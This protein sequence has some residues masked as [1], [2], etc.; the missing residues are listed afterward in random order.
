M[1]AA[2]LV[3]LGAKAHVLVRELVAL[4]GS[5]EAALTDDLTGLG[6]RRSLLS[7]LE[8]A[9]RG[10]EPVALLLLDLDRFKHVNDGLGHH[11]GDE[12]LRQVA[13]RLRAAMVPGSVLARLGG[14]EFAVLLT[15]P[16][17]RVAEEVALGVHAALQRP[18]VVDGHEVHAPGSV[19][20]ALAPAGSAP[21]RGRALDLLRRADTAM[22]A[23]KAA[24]SGVV[25][26][27]QHHDQRAREVIETAEELRAALAGDQ[28]L[29]HY[30]PQLAVA[31]G[32]LL[33]VEALL[34][35]EHPRRGLLGP[36]T[37]LGAAHELGVLA[38]VT[39]LVLRTA[40]AQAAAWRDAGT[41]VRVS[42][43]LTAADVQLALVGDVAELLA[44][45][46][47]P[48]RLLVLEITETSVLE[49]LL[50]AAAVLEDL[51]ALGVE[52]SVDDFGT[53]HSSLTLLLQLPVTEVKV[54]R[55]FVGAVCHDP[56]R[57]TVVRTTVE[58]AHGLGMRVVA[59]GVEDAA[60]LAQLRELG[61][62]ASQ[63]YLHS[64]ALAPEQL[65]CWMRA[66]T[67]V[68]AG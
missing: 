60:V 11:A 17:A 48:P 10:H 37:F 25:V 38:D 35:W 23:A 6:N 66:R 49:D 19:G 52:I 9:L 45:H 31:D 64:R 14:D 5:H 68:A 54:D 59:E 41:P 30:Q 4:Q 56:A 16:A 29:L 32:S 47:L 20:V 51:V 42:V 58:L 15:G 33:G 61:C 50:G 44:A 12:L 1:A 57:R 67:A 39:R 13:H 40:V 62:D 21:A 3:L 55:S 65:T 43:N 63:G 18:A 27:G 53:G 2:A 46:D 34:R 7:A 28:L 36:D 26:H 24:R 8:G 22:Y